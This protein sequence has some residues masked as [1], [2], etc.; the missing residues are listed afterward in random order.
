MFWQMMFAI[1]SPAL[2]TGAFADRVKF[3]AYLVFISFWILIVYCP[4][5]H[6][7]W[8]PKGFLAREFSMKQLCTQVSSMLFVLCG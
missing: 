3:K 2:I 7:V 8:S 5:V 1:I 6:W 4:F